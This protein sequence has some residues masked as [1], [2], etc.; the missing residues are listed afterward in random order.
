MWKILKL[1]KLQSSEFQIAKINAKCYA[2]H[3][4]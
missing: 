4:E 1:S 2:N 3:A